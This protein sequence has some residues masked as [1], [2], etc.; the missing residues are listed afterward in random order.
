[1][2]KQIDP[3]LTSAMHA[4]AGGQVEQ[5]EFLCRSVL[6]ERK[7]D[8]LAMAL[9]A[10]VCNH[11]GKYD[12]AIELIKNAIAKNGKRAD[13]HG[14]LADM[15][16][17]RGEFRAAI[18]AY[19]KAL[20]FQPNHPGVLAGKAN[21]WLRLSEPEKAIALLSGAM[22]SGKEDLTVA[23]VYAKALIASGKPE[24]AASALLVHVPAEREPI[25]TRRMLYFVLGKAM[26]KAGEYQSAFEAYTQGNK[27]TRDSFDFEEWNAKLNDIKLAFPVGQVDATVASS[28]TDGSRV[29]IVGMLRSGSTLT[30]QIIDAHPDGVGLGEIEVFPNILQH[31]CNEES[32][33]S[34]WKKIDQHT[35]DAI[36]Q[37][38]LEATKSNAKIVTD[39]QL[40]N[41]QSVGAILSA[42]PNAKIIHCKRNPLSLGLSCFAQKFPPHTN[43][44]ANDLVDIGRYYNGYDTL[45]HHWKELFGNR[46]LDV[47]YETL[48]HHQEEETRRI[49]DFCELPFHD[50]C[51]RFWETRRTVL[52]LSQDQVNQPL[53]ASAVDRHER[54]GELLAPLRNTLQ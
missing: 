6:Q 28:H 7:R 2:E 24:E 43:A 23:T 8:D 47:Q 21:T 46:I 17:V 13:Y 49:L 4:L 38:Y 42:L 14:L 16:T 39:K 22:K 53:Y 48:V 19:D 44:W 34:F 12:E 11:L 27:L 31:Y 26:E 41:F 52:T 50:R 36:A 35:L 51:M 5:A 9:L 32:F 25:E 20:K 3:R 29:F 45:M 15:L 33:S 10:Q 1:M 54:F 18:G 30:E 37:E 40:S